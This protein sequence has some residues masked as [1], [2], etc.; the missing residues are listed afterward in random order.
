MSSGHWHKVIFNH[1]Y[2]I[3]N[4]IISLSLCVLECRDDIQEES[5]HR[6]A[7]NDKVVPE[8]ARAARLSDEGEGVDHLQGEY[9]LDHYREQ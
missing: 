7:D 6:D 9:V 1:R 5:S 4:A 8:R 2:L 3:D